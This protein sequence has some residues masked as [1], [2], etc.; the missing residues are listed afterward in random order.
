MLDTDNLDPREIPIYSIPQ[1]AQYLR[2]PKDRLRDW[3]GGW[4]QNKSGQALL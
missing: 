4:L 1:A 2:M 3:V